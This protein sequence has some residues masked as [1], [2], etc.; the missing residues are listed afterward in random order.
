MRY[1]KIKEALVKVRGWAVE[2][3]GKLQEKHPVFATGLEMGFAFIP[4]AD[5]PIA[6]LF[7]KADGELFSIGLKR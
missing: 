4:W 1:E 2:K 5:G 6:I 3:W 7:S